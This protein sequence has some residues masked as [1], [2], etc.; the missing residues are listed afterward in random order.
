MQ[1]WEYMFVMCEHSGDNVFHPR[2][3]NSKEIPNWQKGPD[4]ATYSNQSGDQGWELI[5]TLVDS[6]QRKGLMTQGSA[7]SSF[8]LIFKRPKS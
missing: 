4:I 5:E 6:V 8:R 2:F 1:K 7:E 3:V